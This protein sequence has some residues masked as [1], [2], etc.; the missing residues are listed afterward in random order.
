MAY[1]RISPMPIVEGG[2]NAT[3]MTTTDG[4]VYYD[5]TRLV[6][7]AVGTAT[8]VLTSNGA[9]VAPTFQA[10]SGGGLL[11]TSLALTNAQI[12][13]LVATPIQIIAAPGSGNIINI[14]SC[15]AIM[16]YGGNN[17]F[18]DTSTNSIYLFYG[19]NTSA[20]TT[21]IQRV[22]DFNSITA[23]TTTWCTGIQNAAAIQNSYTTAIATN[24]NVIVS[25]PSGSAEIAGNAANDNTI[26]IWVLYTII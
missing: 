1:K 24:K 26:T 14:V 5:G 13:A 15:T 23:T 8:N 19:A 11:S 3:S 17:A 16:I 2:T 6:T 21:G 25:L 20:I 4:V 12:K 10:A 9:G 18:T 22:L 7:T